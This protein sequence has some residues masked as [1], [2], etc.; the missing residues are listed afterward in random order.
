MVRAAE[1]AAG[2]IAPRLALLRALAEEDTVTAAAHRLR[3]PQPTAS[4]WLTALGELLGTPVVATAGRGIRL[5]EAGRHLADASVRALGV[6]EGGCRLALAEADPE[7]GHVVLAF[8][9]TMGGVRVP[10]L[11][12]GFRAQ[13]PHVRFT[14]VQGPHQELCDQVLDGTADLAL[15]SPLPEDD[16][17]LRC[18]ALAEQPL[19]FVAPVAHRLAGRSDVRVAELAGEQFV[20]LKAGYGLRLLT[21][22]LCARAGF[23]PEL[24]FSGE[25]VD[26][27][28]GMVAAELGIALLPASE[29]APA[30][31]TAE[32]SLRPAARRAI[33][34]VWHAER[35]LT[36]AVRLFRDYA[37]ATARE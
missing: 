2:E 32:I 4:R 5:T 17:H 30:P 22:E 8:L 23:T 1:L 3:I 29:A 37:L 16:E 33:G 20:G 28:R 13:H 14:L 26:T 10:E 31:G 21:D 24:A 35:A 27:L 11:L 19:V 18:A 34:L 25:E 7:R 15:T 6:L 12:R 9:H 36:P